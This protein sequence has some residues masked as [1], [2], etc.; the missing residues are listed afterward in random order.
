MN[1]LRT[2]AIVLMVAGALGLAY[3]GFTY[4]RE[5]TAVKFGPLEIS[6]KERRPVNVPVWIGAGGVAAGLLLLL[7]A[8]TRKK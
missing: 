6:V 8:G 4:T 1:S 2:I 7:Y 5:T 3:G